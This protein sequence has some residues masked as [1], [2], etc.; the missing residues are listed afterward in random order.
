M[1]H[2]VR[3]RWNRC[4]WD[5]PCKHHRRA[6]TQAHKGSHPPPAVPAARRCPDGPHRTQTCSH[7]QSTESA[8]SAFVAHSHSHHRP[9]T[10]LLRCR[11][12]HQCIHNFLRTTLGWIRK[13]NNQRHPV[14]HRSQL[15]MA[16]IA[17]RQLRRSR[18]RGDRA[19]TPH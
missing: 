17:R 8:R 11:E 16:G 14:R 2:R 9:R 15:D 19:C 10:H 4:R 3:H 7:R 5:M 13:E 6:Q 12:A 18:F 1:G